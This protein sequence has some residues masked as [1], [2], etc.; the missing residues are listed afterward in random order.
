M[1]K[2]GE[3]PFKVVTINGARL[4]VYSHASLSS[5]SHLITLFNFI[6]SQNES[7]TKSFLLQCI[8]SPQM[9]EEM[10]VLAWYSYLVGEVVTITHNLLT[11]SEAKTLLSETMTLLENSV[12]QHLRTPSDLLD[13]EWLW[14]L[15]PC[16]PSMQ[17]HF[18]C[19]QNKEKFTTAWRKAHKG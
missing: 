3:A 9:R 1:Q 6:N 11:R 17:A 14:E 12:Q 18:G 8:S 19:E 4:H 5:Y 15:M 13:T 2:K 16:F 10:W 7:F